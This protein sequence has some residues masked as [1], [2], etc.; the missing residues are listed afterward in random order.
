[1]K[2]VI[3]KI[4]TD[5]GKIEACRV[6]NDKEHEFLDMSLKR[7][8]EEIEAGQ[9]IVGFKLTQTNNY[10]SGDIKRNLTKERGKFNFNKVPVITGNGELVNEAEHDLLTVIAWHGFAEAKKYICVDY[11][12]E[13]TELNKEEFIQQVKA[14]KINGAIISDKTGKI[15]IMDKLNKEL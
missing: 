5:T 3:G 11:K 6:F 1:M 7:I 10:M 15:V 2:V 12:G 14:D 13:N 9:E 4:M 8:R